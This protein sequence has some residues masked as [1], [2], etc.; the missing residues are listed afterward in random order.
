VKLHFQGARHVARALL[1]RYS[2]SSRLGSVAS[3]A[4]M[5]IA[6]A[7]PVA[8]N[9]TRVANVTPAPGAGV[10]GPT[11]PTIAI[12]AA[13]GG[14]HTRLARSSPPNDTILSSPPRAVTL[15]FTKPVQPKLSRLQ[16]TDA[17]GTKVGTSALR[18]TSDSATT[19]MVTITGAMKPGAYL[20]TWSTT[21]RDSHV[22][23][24]TLR[25]KI[26][27]SAKSD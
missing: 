12:D 5:A 9:A 18:V 2:A 8:A 23:K 20:V 22:I 17:S 26:T 24:G 16:L 14:R 25:F 11:G 1:S 13:A 10:I 6:A 27:G 3:L 4:A 19:L 15:W 7:M 21:S